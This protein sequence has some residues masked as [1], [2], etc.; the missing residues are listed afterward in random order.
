MKRRPPRPLPFAEHLHQR[1]EPVEKGSHAQFGSHLGVTHSLAS[2]GSVTSCVKGRSDTR[3]R[4]EPSA[5]AQSWRAK[6]TIGSGTKWNAASPGSRNFCRFLIRW[7]RLFS[8]NR[9][10]FASAVMLLCVRRATTLACPI[11]L[12]F[13]TR[14]RRTRHERSTKLE[15][16]QLKRL[17]AAPAS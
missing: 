2:A 15:H 8:V 6:K 17:M 11:P 13:V 7:E 3:Q 16:E 4:G 5:D 12:G 9:S 10:G 14:G 1:L